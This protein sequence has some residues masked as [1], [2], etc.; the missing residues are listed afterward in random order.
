MDGVGELPMMLMLRVGVSLAH[1]A[2]QLLLCRGIGAQ[3][4]GELW[5]ARDLAYVQR[6]FFDRFLAPVGDRR[7]Q[8]DD[9]ETQLRSSHNVVG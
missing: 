8:T 3:S 4:A 2:L 7:A 5:L 9:L 1:I 6:F